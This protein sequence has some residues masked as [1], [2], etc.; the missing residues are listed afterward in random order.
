MGET[1]MEGKRK[2]NIVA[3]VKIPTKVRISYEVT[4]EANIMPILE[5]ILE[6]RRRSIERI[7]SPNGS[8]KKFVS[9]PLPKKPTRVDKKKVN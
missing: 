3:T 5:Q 7:P 9:K 4:D 2:V 1:A 6:Q 8:K